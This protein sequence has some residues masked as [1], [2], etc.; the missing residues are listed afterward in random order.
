M[1]PE[2]ARAGRADVYSMFRTRARV[3]QG[4]LALEDGEKKLSYGT[5]LD[6]VDRLA[7]VL[8]ARRVKT[9][10]RVVILSHNRGE[11][12]ELQLAAAAIGAIIACLNWRLAAPE[13]K[14]CIDLVEPVLAVA[15]PELR[16]A[17]DAVSHLPVL[18]IGPNWEAAL[19]GAEPDPRIDLSGVDVQ[20]KILIL[21]REAGYTME[22]ADVENPGFLPPALMEG[23]VQGFLEGL[24]TAEDGMQARLAEAAAKGLQLRYVATFERNAQGQP[25]AQVGLQALP[26]EHPFCQLQ[27]SDNVVMLQTDRYADRP[28]IVQGAGAGADVTAMGVFADIMRFAATR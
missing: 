8:L 26:P 18:E 5:L 12:L 15:E 28:L 2:V 13:L 6:R 9:G 3:Q 10:D 17:L 19:A 20:R 21:A 22:M 14:H 1:L 7:A 4:V 23:S 16:A 11:Y 25:T 24:P 27:G